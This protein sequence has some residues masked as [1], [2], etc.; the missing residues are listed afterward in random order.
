[1]FILPNQTGFEKGDIAFYGNIYRKNTIPLFGFLFQEIFFR[2][3]RFFS[4]LTGFPS[5]FHRITN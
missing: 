2:P 4:L 5:F 1:M 3:Q